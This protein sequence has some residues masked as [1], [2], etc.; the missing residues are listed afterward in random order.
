MAYAEVVNVSGFVGNFK[1]T[2]KKKARYGV[3][4]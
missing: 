1:V 4:A 3:Q 2:V